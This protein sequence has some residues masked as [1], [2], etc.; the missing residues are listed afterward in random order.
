MVCRGEIGYAGA[1]AST[2][3][4][5]GYSPTGKVEDVTPDMAASGVAEVFRMLEGRWKM[6]VI[7]HLFS[8]GV[9]RFLWSS[10]APSPGFRRRC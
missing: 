7:F 5:V 1:M 6:V 2:D 10:S 8:R 4:K 3:K 9:L